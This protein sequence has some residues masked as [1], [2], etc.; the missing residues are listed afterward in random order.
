MDASI[1]EGG[2]PPNL[3]FHLSIQDAALVLHL[4]TLAPIHDGGGGGGGSAVGSGASTPTTHPINEVP[5]LSLRQRF[6]LAEKLPLHDESGEIFQL[7]PNWHGFRSSAYSS[8]STDPL[9]A[10]AAAPAPSNSLSSWFH[11][12]QQRAT[13]PAPPSSSFR[14]QSPSPAVVIT[15][16]EGATMGATRT[17]L[18]APATRKGREGRREGGGGGSDGVGG[19]GGGGGGVKV[20]VR[21]KVRVESQDPA[22]MAV[23]AKLSALGHRVEGRRGCLGVLMG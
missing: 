10:S 2:L 16:P 18:T 23:M 14:S 13:S 19:G 3:S 4:R 7:S 9:S 22:L 8:T 17:T 12:I 1:F 5:L 15:G 6:G 20:K 21:E 11:Q